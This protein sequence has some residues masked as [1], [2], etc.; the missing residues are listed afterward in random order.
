MILIEIHP[1][2][3]RIVK[4]RKDPAKRFVFQTAYA[5]VLKP[6][7]SAQPHPLAFEISIRDGE[8]PY[9]PGRYQL[10]PASVF[11][12]Q[13]EKGNRRLALAPKLV[14]LPAK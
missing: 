10:A 7:G 14:P 12:S 6:D 4:G 1:D 11:V 3:A 13:D 8:S 5:H 2:S 9:S